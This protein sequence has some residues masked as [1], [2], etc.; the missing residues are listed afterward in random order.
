MD[1]YE[2]LD[3]FLDRIVLSGQEDFI[4]N[5]QMIREAADAAFDSGELADYQ[6]RSLITRSA[7]IQDMVL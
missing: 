5:L 6:W 3:G 2:Q 4:T 1:K 7:K